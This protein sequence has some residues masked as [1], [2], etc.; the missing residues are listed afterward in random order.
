GGGAVADNFRFTAGSDSAPGAADTISDFVHNIDTSA[1]GAIDAGTSVMGN[2]PFA[3]CGNNGG[4]NTHTVTWFESGGNTIIH[5]DVD[6]DTVP[7]LEIV[8]TG[9]A[10][11]L[12]AADFIL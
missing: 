7:E 8:L 4:T 11:G 3:F 5:A 12:T 2:P 6:G 1:L 9:T 10:L